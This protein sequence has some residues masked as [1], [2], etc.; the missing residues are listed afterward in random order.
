M[1]V[2]TKTKG[3]VGTKTKGITT[4][5]PCFSHDGVVS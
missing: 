3:I 2:G 1:V 4:V 5:R